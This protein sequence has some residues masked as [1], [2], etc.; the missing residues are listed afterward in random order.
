MY[1]HVWL[2][3]VWEYAWIGHIIYRYWGENEN[4]Y[5]IVCVNMNDCHPCC[6]IKKKRKGVYGVEI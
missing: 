4:I 1:L 5:I 2:G 6:V 3:Y